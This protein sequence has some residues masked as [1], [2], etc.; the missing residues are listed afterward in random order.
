M[1]D[2]VDLIARFFIAFMFMFEAIDS[3]F[4]FSETKDTMTAYGITWRQDLVLSGLIVVLVL[5]A[6]LVALGY[7]A[8]FGGFLLL[9]YWIP[10]TFIVYD[11]WNEADEAMRRLHGL[12][13][14]RNMAV[15]SA[16]LLLIAN[17]AGRFS[18]KRLVHVMRLPK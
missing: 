11:F 16:L 6:V 10:F 2:I 14:M 8:K 9:L 3:I 12:Y 4:Y 17:G 13:F 5:G 18:I 15:V 1:K 7:L